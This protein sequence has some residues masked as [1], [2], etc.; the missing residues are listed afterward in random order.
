MSINFRTR[1]PKGDGNRLKLRSIIIILLIF[2]NTNPERGRKLSFAAHYAQPQALFQNTNPER[3][4]KPEGLRESSRQQGI[5]EHEPRKG[6]ET[7]LVPPWGIKDIHFR[8]RTP[9]GDGNC[10]EPADWQV[11]RVISEH[12]PRK[13]TETANIDKLTIKEEFISEHEPRKGTE[14][15]AN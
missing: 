10:E 5:S 14:T 8:T 13:G 15:T 12:E 1:T 7:R 6:T 3:G 2:Q 4:R 11:G 9:K